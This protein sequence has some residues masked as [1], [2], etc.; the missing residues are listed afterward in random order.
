MSSRGSR[1]KIP[2]YSRQLIS[3]TSLTAPS[4]HCRHPCPPPYHNNSLSQHHT[5]SESTTPHAA[6]AAA[7]AVCPCPCPCCI[8]I[9]CLNTGKHHKHQQLHFPHARLSK[10]PREKRRVQ[11]KKRRGRGGKGNS[12]SSTTRK[13]FPLPVKMP[14][15]SFR[16]APSSLT[17][18][19]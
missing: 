14:S 6:A 1:L 7:A 16:L 15:R 4:H 12:P 5:K 8:A 18:A 9:F 11:P 13:L 10:T 3:H 17:L 19:V 2:F